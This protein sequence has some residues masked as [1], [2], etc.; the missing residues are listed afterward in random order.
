MGADQETNMDSNH[1]ALRSEIGK[2][3]EFAKCKYTLNRLISLFPTIE[4][5]KL[6]NERKLF[7]PQTS[8]VQNRTRAMGRSANRGL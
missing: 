6:K 2:I 8:N 5:K 1:P 3:Q 4:K 7:R